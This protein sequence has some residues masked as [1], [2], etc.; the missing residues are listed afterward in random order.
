VRLSEF[1]EPV[2]PSRGMSHRTNVSPEESVAA[3]SLAAVCREA[4]VHTESQTAS[5]DTGGG[6][7]VAAVQVRDAWA[8]Y[9]EQ[10]APGSWR[11]RRRPW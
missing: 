3:P 11:R 4:T 8:T 2:E 7:E 6:I 1:A 10:S 9:A 5:P